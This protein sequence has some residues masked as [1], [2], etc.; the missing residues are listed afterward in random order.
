MDFTQI[1]SKI[2]LLVDIG[3]VVLIWM[4][5]LIVYPSFTFYSK[6]NLVNWHQK[7]TARIAVIVIPLMFLQLI[8]VIVD[9]RTIRI[10]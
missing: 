3:L 10:P 6:E 8:L 2:T 9:I 1:I 7:Y 5:Q 4:V